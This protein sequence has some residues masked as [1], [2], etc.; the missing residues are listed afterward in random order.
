MKRIKVSV[1]A[2]LVGASMVLM[3]S[4]IGSF[5]LFNKVL[6]W[7]KKATNNKWVNE[8]IFV[9]LTIIP[10]YEVSY[11][12]DAILFNSLEFWTGQSPLANVDVTV[13]GE[14]GEYHVKS[15]TNGYHVELLGSNLS[16]DFLFDEAT[17]TWSLSENGKQTKLVQFVDDNTAKFYTGTSEM[18]VDMASTLNLLA[19]R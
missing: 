9:C 5:S 10:V 16:A 13:K 17:K 7:N 15:T 1:A 18:T 8:L 11:F 2:L 19:A 6:D 3:S 12:L 14:K 4:C